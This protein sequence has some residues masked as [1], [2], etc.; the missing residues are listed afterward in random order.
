MSALDSFRRAV[1][2]KTWEVRGIRAVAG[3]V[4]ELTACSWGNTEEEARAFFRRLQ[5]LWDK[6][7][8]HGQS[9]MHWGDDEL[10]FTE[11]AP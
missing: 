1:A 7:S 8:I 11:V 10:T 9:A 6:Q 5:A 2:G 4:Q 3:G